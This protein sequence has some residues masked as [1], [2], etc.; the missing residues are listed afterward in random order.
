MQFYKLINEYNIEICDRY[1]ILK[2]RSGMTSHSSSND[3]NGL[4]MQYSKVVSPHSVDLVQLK[5]EFISSLLTLVAY[6]VSSKS[7]REEVLSYVLCK[8]A[9]YAFLTS[10]YRVNH[11]RLG[12]KILSKLLIV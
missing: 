4:R 10:I 1:V 5:E 3:S 6:E 2:A 12:I 7:K 9:L 8:Y 11:L